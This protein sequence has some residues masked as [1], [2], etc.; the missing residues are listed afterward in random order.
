MAQVILITPFNLLGYKCINEGQDKEK[1]GGVMTKTEIIKQ[2][3]EEAGLA[4]LVQAK[5]AYN[6]L[7]SLLSNT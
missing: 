1:Y 3:K 7:F 6:S 5:N 2:L 4:S